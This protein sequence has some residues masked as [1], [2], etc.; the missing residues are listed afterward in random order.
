MGLFQAFY[1]E[2]LRD[3]TPWLILAALA[4]R[5]VVRSADPRRMRVT[6][7]FLAIHVVL[8]VTTA[9]LASLGADATRD[10]H[11]AAAL[12]AGMAGVSIAGAL[13]FKAALPRLRISTPQILQDVVIA[14]TGLVTLLLIASRSGINLSGIV[15]TSAVLTAVIGLSLQDTLGNILGGLALQTDD[16]IRVGDWVKVGDV[17]GRVVDI[18]WRYTA[19]ETRNWET[20]VLPNSVLLKNQVIVLGRRSGQPLQ[21][22]RWVWFNVDFRHAPTDVIQTVET[23]LRSSP[24]QNVAAE[25]APQC[26]VMDFTESWGRYAARYWLTDLAH[27]DGTDNLVRQ[28]IYFAL[29]RAGVQLSIPAHAVFVTEDTGERR[30]E[31]SK[32][33]SQRREKA[34]ASVDLFANMSDEDRHHLATSLKYAPF[35]KGEALTKQGA[36]AHWLYII[37]KGECSVRVAAKSGEKEVA[38]LSGGQFF[39]EMSLLTGAERSATVVALSDVE[40]WRL[41]REVFKELLDRRPEVAEDVAEILAT[42]QIGLDAARQELDAESRT[43]LMAERKQDIVDKIRSFF[44]VG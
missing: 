25:P 7:F 28:R 4:A 26:I 23:A 37:S 14:G 11:L 24:I 18:R 15:A 16:S 22:R 43:S 21:W 13:I 30:A 34:L 27:D 6:M 42:R 10:V 5:A 2:A 20:V 8:V 12:V 33:E 39:G 1:D 17:V 19:I 3:F 38:R 35:T 29:Q 40:C 36:K 44:G 31:K 41:D 32:T 9:V